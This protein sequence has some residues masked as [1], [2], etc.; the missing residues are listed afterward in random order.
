MT[1]FGTSWWRASSKPTTMTRARLHGCARAMN[2]PPLVSVDRMT[3]A[4]RA[5]RKRLPAQRRQQRPMIDIRALSPLWHKKRSAKTVLHRAICQTASGLGVSGGEVSV[6]LTNDSA[7][8]ELNRT[9]RRRDMPTNVLSFPLGA[10]GAAGPKP[11]LLG[12]IVIA[13]ETTARE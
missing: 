11:P 3:S 2:E 10:G 12:D 7:I 9:W 6:V 8:R 4:T 1:S 13:Y 5:G